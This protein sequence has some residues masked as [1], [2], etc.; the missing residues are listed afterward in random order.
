MTAFQGFWKNSRATVCMRN[1]QVEMRKMISCATK[2]ESFML[3]TMRNGSTRMQ[4]V[5]RIQKLRAYVESSYRPAVRRS[6]NLAAVP[7]MASSSCPR[8]LSTSRTWV[9]SSA[10]NLYCI[11]CIIP[12]PVKPQVLGRTVT[13]FVW[14]T[15]GSLVPAS[16]PQRIGIEP[17]P[18]RERER[19]LIGTAL[20]AS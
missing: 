1:S 2:L 3:Y 11:D 18:G 20:H 15:S 6:R 5:P 13:S 10:R 4:S 14:C 17:K 16:S 19:E 9:Q 12:D 8:I 7:A